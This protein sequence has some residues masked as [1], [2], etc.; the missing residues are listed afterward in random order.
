MDSK[1]KG[2]KVVLGLSGGVDSAVSCYLLLKQG[3]EVIPVFMKN[4]D[5]LI[6]HDEK[7]DENKNFDGCESNEDYKMAQ[8]IAKH[9]KLKLH[10][11]EFIEQY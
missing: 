4:W 1:L 10:K 7:G 8:K 6:N 5:R 11:V 2:K 3:Y 9:F